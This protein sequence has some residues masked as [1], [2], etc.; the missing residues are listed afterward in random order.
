VLGEGSSH[1]SSTR[2]FAPIYRQVT[3]RYRE[4]TAGESPTSLVLPHQDILAAFLDYLRRYCHGRGFALIGHLQR[5][6]L[7]NKL[8]R[9]QIDPKPALR[10][11]LVAAIILGGDVLVN[12][13]S[14]V[15]GD[16]KHS[17]GVPKPGTSGVRDRFLDLRS[18]PRGLTASSAGHWPGLANGC[19]A[20]TPRG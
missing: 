7:L 17:P 3:V 2:V 18:D 20:R 15:G 1:G 4:R 8:R 19:R 6:L 16:F 5:S 13:G 9:K 11:G 12:S 10:C 14:K